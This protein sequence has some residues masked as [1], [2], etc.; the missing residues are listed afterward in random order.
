M[1]MIIIFF[2]V[3]YVYV[4]EVGGGVFYESYFFAVVFAAEDVHL[5]DLI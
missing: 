4:L 5:D 3:Y 1:V 2:N